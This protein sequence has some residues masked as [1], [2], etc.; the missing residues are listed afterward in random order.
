NILQR[1][2]IPFQVTGGLASIIYGVDRELADIDISIPENKFK[3]ILSDINNY[4]EFGPKNYLD[5]EW[6]LQL[7]TLKYKNQYIDIGGAY[8]KKNFDKTN[9]RWVNTPSNFS[10]SVYREIYGLRVP[11]IA[12]EDLIAYKKI[13]QRDV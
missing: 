9:Q 8:E 12:K 7:M 5:E 1:H 13:I 3:E 10:R 6:D 2:S 11:I 4:I